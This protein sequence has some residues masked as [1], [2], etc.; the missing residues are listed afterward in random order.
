MTQANTTTAINEA[1][2]RVRAVSFNSNESDPYILFHQ[3][4]DELSDETMRRYYAEWRGTNAEPDEDEEFENFLE[5][6]EAGKGFINLTVADRMIN[7]D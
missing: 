5:W 7:F 4:P 2:G 1:T 6:L 3:S